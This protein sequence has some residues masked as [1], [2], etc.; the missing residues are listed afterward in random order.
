M[1]T[2]NSVLSKACL[3]F[4]VLVAT[5]NFA[6][7]ASAQEVRISFL[8][9]NDMGEISGKPGYG[10]FPELAT[11]IEQERARQPNAITTFGGDLISP[12]LMSGLSFGVEMVDMMNAIGID[13]AVVGNHEFDFGAEVARER[14]AQSNFPWLASNISLKEGIRSLGTVSSIIKEVNG[15]KVGFL[16]LVTPETATLS[17][18]G[19]GIVFQDVVKAA[20]TVVSSLQNNGADIIVA[21]THMNLADDLRLANEVDGLH[22]ILGGHDHRPF[23]TVENNVVI[24]QAGS[25]LRY[26]GVV[27]LALE[28]KEKRGKKYLSIIPSWYLKS[29]TAVPKSAPVAEMV[30]KF[31]AGLDQQLNVAVGI[32]ELALDTRRSS[33]RT[34]EN[35][36]GKYIA[37]AM[38]DEVEADIGFTNGGG[39]RGDRQY[40]A[41]AMLTRKDILGE[42]PFGNVT[43]KLELTGVQVKDMV[44]HGVS[45]VENAAGRF[46]H[47]SGLEYSYDI[48]KPVG[49]RVT[50]IKVGGRKLEPESKYTLAT[51]DY[52]AGGGDGYSMLPDSKVLIDKSAGTLMATTVMNYIKAKGGIKANSVK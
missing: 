27:E 44:E 25:D 2:T 18:P 8:H 32:T 47:Y 26:L 5:I 4:A 52:V 51:N 48:N 21:L 12:S 37:Q 16:G 50:Q 20:S 15:F 9:S 3:F 1:R 28:W 31:E 19:E 38:R 29:T 22:V 49:A 11:L 34:K 6:F 41:G 35:F 39:I 17:S 40:E 46:A 45:D 36:F 14:I 10:G 33:V 42:L 30:A 13:V 43:V 24:L 7:V 23:A